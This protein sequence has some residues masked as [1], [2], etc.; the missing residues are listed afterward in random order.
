MRPTFII[1]Q[2]REK[3]YPAKLNS[4]EVS[5]NV[6][7]GVNLTMLHRGKKVLLGSFDDAVEAAKEI[8]SIGNFESVYY[9]VDGY[10]NGGFAAW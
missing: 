7:G 8:D 4:L 1:D 6:L 10:S 9:S 5:A 3:L 2:D